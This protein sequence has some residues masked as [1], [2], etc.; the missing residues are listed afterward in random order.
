MSEP[1]MQQLLASSYLS[2][3][4]ASY[5]EELYEQFLADPQALTPEW[6]S[7]FAA[8]PRVEGQPAVDNS[9]AVVRQRLLESAQQARSQV[10]TAL[11]ADAQF[12]RK[13]AAVGRLIQAYR[14]YGHLAAQIDPLQV[15]RPR[16]TQLQ[17]DYYPELTPVDYERSFRTEGVMDV[18]QASLK[19]I[20][21]TLNDIYCGSLGVEYTYVASLTELLWLQQRLERGR[22]ALSADEQREI[23]R[24]L[25]AAEGLERY[26]AT[27]YVAQKR[28]SL[29]GGDS[30]IPFVHAVNERAAANGVQ[31]VLIGMAHRGR[32]N[33]LINVFGKAPQ[34]LFQEFEGKKDFGL[35]SGDVKYHLGCSS[36]IATQAGPL[37]LTLAFNPSHL[38]IIA[39]VLMGSVR[40][41]QD[42]R[43]A[44][45]MPDVMGFLV[46]GDASFAGQGVIME[47]L[48]MSQT[49]AYK[50]AGTV[51]VVINNQIGFT[52]SNPDDARSGAYCTD[53]AKIIAAPVLHVNGDDPEAVVFAARLA[54]DYRKQFN[55]DIV[56]DLVCYRRLGHNEADEPIATQP[57]MYTFIR[58]HPSVR[59]LYAAQLV[60]QGVCT[61]AEVEA[62]VQM[63]RDLLDAAQPIV[64]TFSDGLAHHYATNW[65]PYLEQQWTAPADTAVDAATLFDLGTAL[66]TIPEGFELQ[67][68][69]A[70]IIQARAEMA[71]GK[72]P[73]DWGYAE[74]LAYATLLNQGYCVRMSGQDCRR[75][76]FAH[77]HAVLH[78]Q[79]TG[80][81]YTPLEHINSH[82]ASFQIFDSLLSEA[83]AMGFEYGYASTNPETLTLWE[84]QYGDFANGAQVI[85]D[86]FISSAWQKWRTLSGL[87]L[88]LPHGYEGA[89]PEHTS[90]RLERYLQLCAQENI[91]VCIPT[92]PAQIFHLL[93]RQVLRPFRVPLIILT[94]KNILRHKLAVSQLSELSSGQFQLIIPEHRTLASRLERVVLC[95]GKVYYDLLAKQLERNINTIPLVRIEQLYPFPTDDV[96]AVLRQYAKVTDIVWCQE[97]PEN[98]GAWYTLRH[99]LEA[100]LAKG[101]RIHY[102]GRAPSASPA[103]G[104]MKLHVQQQEQLVE[105]AL[106]TS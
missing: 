37:H 69:V 84:A 96:R 6:R 76:T 45:H 35:T 28:F 87:T 31:E 93:R 15:E 17:L 43:G 86:Q 7:Y 2:A 44:D 78:D 49:R 106:T 60:A 55:K 66:T 82:Q 58:Q 83:G 98:Q 14:T 26:L 36:D 57:L 80:H 65:Q 29:E 8:L 68:Q 70:H 90:A 100:C 39:P 40:A 23:L 72:L 38:E 33:M 63:Y 22:V 71:A 104:Y 61:Q 59:E 12:E 34:E 48:N 91:Q 30:F 16:P 10:T 9:H 19:Q 67:R 53:P 32:L 94:P 95:S 74:N 103:A 18:P 1:N 88:L 42:R 99:H 3:G 105:R 4:N 81:C 75:G 62:L 25:T 47:S 21:A 89:G 102:V 13:Q 5:L 79:K 27:R 97:E 54:T 73:L 52:T 24:Q 101:Q 50:I 20:V 51:H 56:V 77:R 92:T 41:R 85:I 46:H 64:K 11:D